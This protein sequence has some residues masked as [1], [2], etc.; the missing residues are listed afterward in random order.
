MEQNDKLSTERVKSGLLLAG[1]VLSAL[2]ALQLSPVA[3]EEPP[4]GNR[5]KRRDFVDATRFCR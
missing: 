4:A 1:W 3:A 2:C 5:G